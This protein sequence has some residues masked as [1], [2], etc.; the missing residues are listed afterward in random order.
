MFKYFTPRIQSKAEQNTFR[1]KPV[2]LVPVIVRHYRISR[3]WYR[4]TTKRTIKRKMTVRYE[5]WEEACATACLKSI[6]LHENLAKCVFGERNGEFLHTRIECLAGKLNVLSWMASVDPFREVEE[7]SWEIQKEVPKPWRNV[8][9]WNIRKI[10]K[11]HKHYSQCLRFSPWSGN[12]KIGSMSVS[13]RLHT[14]VSPDNK[15]G[16]MLDQ[17]RG[18]GEVA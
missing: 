4:L 7:I 12:R 10:F 16:L 9:C 14:H 15:L 2:W 18:R 11:V 13:E 3:M 17:G 1:L 5:K 8:H 6:F